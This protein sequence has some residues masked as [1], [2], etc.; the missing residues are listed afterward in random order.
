MEYGGY[1]VTTPLRTLLDI[2]ESPSGLS[3]LASA[4]YD[5]LYRGLVRSAQLLAADT[6]DEARK[7]LISAIGAAEQRI[8]GPARKEIEGAEAVEAVEGLG[9]A[10]RQEHNAR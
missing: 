4:V 5:A 3:Y 10:R 2:A 9:T 1:R 6:T 8:Y 7:L